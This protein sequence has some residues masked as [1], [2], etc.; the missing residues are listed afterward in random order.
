MLFTYKDSLSRWVFDL[1]FIKRLL[2]VTADEIEMDADVEMHQCVLWKMLI[3]LFSHLGL[4]QYPE[5]R[6]GAVMRRRC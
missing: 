1:W 3:F 2:T 4:M 6:D 5:L